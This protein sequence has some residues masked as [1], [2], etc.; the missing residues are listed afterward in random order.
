[1]AFGV[2]RTEQGLVCAHLELQEIGTQI[3]ADIICRTL[4]LLVDGLH[5]LD[6]ESSRLLLD[7]TTRLCIMMDGRNA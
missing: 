2:A 6:D 1:M 5:F 7:E 4:C 3:G